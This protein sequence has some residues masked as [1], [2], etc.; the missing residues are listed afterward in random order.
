MLFVKIYVENFGR[1]QIS[2]QVFRLRKLYHPSILVFVVLLGLRR[3]VF[4]DTTMGNRVLFRAMTRVT[5]LVKVM[6]ALN[7]SRHRNR[8]TSLI[9][10]FRN[11]LHPVRNFRNIFRTVALPKMRGT[12]PTLYLAVIRVNDP[13]RVLPNLFF[14]RE[15]T[16][17]TNRKMNPSISGNLNA[18]NF[19]NLL[20]RLVTLFVIPNG[21]LAMRMVAN[22]N[23]RAVN[24]ARLY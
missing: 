17:I 5:K 12:R 11:L 8:P 7:S 23:V 1:L 14:V 21:A 15:V 10:L 2:L 18:T 19:Y 24:V 13:L 16:V 4:R 9:V 22:R 6:F 20:R 3:N